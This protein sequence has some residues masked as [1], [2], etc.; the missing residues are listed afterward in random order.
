MVIVVELVLADCGVSD[1]VCTAESSY[2]VA[3]LQQDAL[4]LMRR[5]KI[6]VGEVPAK[7]LV[8]LSGEPPFEGLDAKLKVSSN[9]TKPTGIV[10]AFYKG[11]NPDIQLRLPAAEECQELGKDF[12]RENWDDDIVGRATLAGLSCCEQAALQMKAAYVATQNMKLH[13]N[14]VKSSISKELLS[15]ETCTN[16]YAQMMSGIES[17]ISKLRQVSVPRAIREQFVM[18]LHCSAPDPPPTL[19]SDEENCNIE[20][21]EEESSSFSPQE[22]D[23]ELYNTLDQCV[24]LSSLQGWLGECERVATALKAQTLAL[25]STQGEITASSSFVLNKSVFSELEASN[26]AVRDLMSC[27]SRDASIEELQQLLGKAVDVHIQANAALQETMK[28]I[29]SVETKI[30]Q[31]QKRVTRLRQGV[32]GLR[33]IL[34]KL[35][36]IE[37]LPDVFQSSLDEVRRRQEFSVRYTTELSR[38]AEETAR[39]CNEEERKR[40]EFAAT[41][42]RFLP[43]GLIPGLG[44]ASVPKCEFV[45]RPFDQELPDLD[46]STK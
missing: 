16:S 46:S 29:R 5:E 3:Q 39:V 21:S 13:C 38:M 15:Y 11:N 33:S 24:D 40:K 1:T 18:Q 9:C 28:Q 17:S 35:R 30:A 8:L 26:F 12:A 25:R 43:P 7:D 45:Q 32:Q 10:F 23:T 42:G 6:V 14:S 20:R 34:D 31:T 4:S 2:T 41:I 44:E 37:K 19:H 22:E 36:L 27:W